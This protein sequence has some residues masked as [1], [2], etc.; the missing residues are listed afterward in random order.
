MKGDREKC[1]EAGMDDYI[2]KPINPEALFSVIRKVHHES[3]D[4]KEQDKK[5][6]KQATTSLPVSKFYSPSTFDLEKA[7]ETVLDSKDLFQ[8]IA[9]MFLEKLPEY[10]AG[11]REAI[12]EKDS[13]ALER[14]AHALKGSVGNF[15]A[16]EAFDAAFRLE[17][18]GKYGKMDAL[19]EELSIL[20]KSFAELADEMKAVLKD[21][22]LPLKSSG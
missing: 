20:E 22:R 15:G 7:M 5:E 16:R 6:Q 13:G 14:A 9:G 10:I 11:I 1:L 8:E 17:K 18:S 19:E 21:M 3:L 4:K 2:S 12:A